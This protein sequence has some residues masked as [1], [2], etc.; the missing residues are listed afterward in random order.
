MA[1]RPADIPLHRLKELE[2]GAPTRNLMEQIALNQSALWNCVLSSR[3][4]PPRELRSP[5]L[6][7]RMWSGAAG[8]YEELGVQ[9]LDVAIEWQSDT[10][11]AWGALSVGLIEGI[12]LA[13]RLEL[14]RP[15]AADQ[16]F[17]VREWA[18]IAVRDHISAEL[19][20]AVALLTNWTSDNDENIRRFASEATRP[21]G[22][23]C[24]HIPLL[25]E[26]PDLAIQILEPLRSDPATYV[27]LS[28]GN[29]LNDAAKSRPE[30]VRDICKRWLR[31]S[32]T[33][34]TARICKRGTR[35]IRAV[36]GGF[37]APAPR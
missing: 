29:W 10:A 15:F 37:A 8:I 34:H 28:V 14:A 30:W 26:Q 4:D 25:K 7:D 17:A 36:G 22:V 21:R 9:C 24:K 2:N 20:V 18:W 19:S 27:Q 12:P 3:A 23:W 5:R 11:R 16:H 1:L 33:P 32:S 35:S 6:T 31:Q 13:E